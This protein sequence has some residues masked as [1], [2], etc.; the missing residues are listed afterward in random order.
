MFLV[1]ELTTRNLDVFTRKMHQV[2]KYTF[3]A[4]VFCA[5][6]SPQNLIKILAH[7]TEKHSNNKRAHARVFVC[8]CRTTHTGALEA[9][10]L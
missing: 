4:F 1:T 3:C 7:C 8:V 9:L 10:G 5:H 2:K 6:V